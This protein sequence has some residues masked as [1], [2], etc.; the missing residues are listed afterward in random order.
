MK[1]AGEFRQYYVVFT[2]EARLNWFFKLFTRKGFRHCEI[3]TDVTDDVSM[4]ICQ[5]L[6][7]V[8]FTY[9]NYNIETVIKELKKSNSKILY[10]PIFK[11]PRKL[12]LG[13]MIPSCVS[14]CMMVTGLSFNSITVHGYYRALKKNGAIEI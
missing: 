6:E 14:N 7:N 5:T 3:Y 4:S 12:R 1:Q 8:E 13:I 2:N 11:K 9:Y 10:L